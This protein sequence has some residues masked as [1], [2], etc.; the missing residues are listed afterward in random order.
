MAIKGIAL[1]DKHGC[2]RT[3]QRG[4]AQRVLPR[5]RE[6]LDCDAVS[7]DKAPIKGDHEWVVFVLASKWHA[8]ARTYLEAWEQGGR[9]ALDEHYGR[10]TQEENVAAF[11][12]AHPDLA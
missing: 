3:M 9:D 10:P 12:N 11:K 1:L 2:Y 6:H 4:T 8:R 5:L 7:L